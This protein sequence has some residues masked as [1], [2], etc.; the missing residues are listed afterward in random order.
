MQTAWISVSRAC[1][2]AC[3][4]C[5]VAD[6]LDRQPID[7]RALRAELDA[8]LAAGAK[9]VVFTGGEP[10]LSAQLIAALGYARGRGATTAIATNGRLLADSE[11]VTRLAV[12][13]LNELWL[14]LHGATPAIHDALV[15]APAHREAMAALAASTGTFG[16]R[17]RT[18]LTATNLAELPA[19]I[20]LA[21]QH[22]AAFELRQLRRV[23]AG[24]DSADALSPADAH[25]A[26][27]TTLRAA[28]RLGV[29]FHHAGFDGTGQSGVPAQPV[30]R[31]LD[32]IDLE[33]LQAGVRT[34]AL[35]GGLRSPPADLLADAARA[36]RVAPPELLTQ[37]AARRV[38]LR[39]APAEHGGL[40]PASMPA[41]RP[42]A[43]DP[44]PRGAHVHVLADRL[45]QPL[46]AASALP[47]L[48]HE[49]TA[50]G[51][52][53]T[54]HWPF[55]TPFEANT[56]AP[57]A[58][59]M[60]TLSRF[61]SRAARLDDAFDPD[62]SAEHQAVADAVCDAVLAA[63]GPR[64]I[65]G[66]WRAHARLAPRLPAD[67]R[68]VLLD[69]ACLRDAASAPAP[70]D[71]VRSPHPAHAAAYRAVGLS[72]RALHWRPFPIHEPHLPA[73][74]PPS[75]SAG[76]VVLGDAGDLGLPGW[77]TGS[78]LQPLPRRWP[79]ALAA[80]A[81]ARLVWV[82]QLGAQDVA[83]AAWLSL[84][85][86]LGRPIVGPDVLSL[87]DHARDDHEG[88]LYGP[89]EHGAAVVRALYADAAAL[90]RL[91][92]G[93]HRR[94]QLATTRAWA[95]ELV[96]G[97]PPTRVVGLRPDRGPW[98]PW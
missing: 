29:P 63:P 49:L 71:V 68:W 64:V 94:G 7:A 87:S 39:D 10:T 25:A 9:R 16:L 5:A 20:A 32:E 92:Q 83:P 41:D 27:D 48:A 24:R 84:A 61:V 51:V 14:S 80:L 44:L 12:A 82:P 65:I 11:R 59:L 47:G 45:D 96:A 30:D 98:Y 70:G 54:L 69:D 74:R 22:G 95:R 90:D 28:R 66:S 4:F 86:A 15:G 73:V 6:T 53:V 50:L 26:L 37:W 55:R 35:L 88:R 8:A 85:L 38:T 72:H 79:E 57:R 36:R 75:A 3:R 40:G 21:A 43:W 18:V 52:H 60:G 56:L 23:G 89:D 42:F 78:G 46:L 33:L 19:L 13:G 81:T 77:S 93:A 34:P 67:V 17:L 62:A 91:G 97:A 31:P 58:S 1:N 2:N 76:V